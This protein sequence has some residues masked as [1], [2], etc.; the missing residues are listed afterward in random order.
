[1]YRRHTLA[2]LAAIM[3]VVAVVCCVCTENAGNT[4]NI[5]G[6]S[7]TTAVAGDMSNS[8]AGDMGDGMA[9]DMSNSMAGDM[10]NSMADDMSDGSR[11][12]TVLSATGLTSAEG[13]IIEAPQV[14]QTIPVRRLVTSSSS[15]GFS[16]L[17]II[18][19]YHNLCIRQLAQCADVLLASLCSKSCSV[20]A[21]AATPYNFTRSC[22][23]YVYALRII[24][25]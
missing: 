18:R 7:L 10:S 19:L 6:E 14:P 12:A 8:M 22:E 11:S 25:I 20:F 5:E 13:I 24:V 17:R 16:M 2:I 4:S 21:G 9:G 15:G 23:Y 1:M 3:F